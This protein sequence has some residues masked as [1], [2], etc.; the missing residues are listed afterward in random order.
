M[1]NDVME[2]VIYRKKV[3]RLKNAVRKT[4]FNLKLHVKLS[5]LYLAAEDF[6]MAELEQEACEYI[7]RIKRISKNR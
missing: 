1:V 2:R 6:E 3:Q 5:D 4:P 7:L